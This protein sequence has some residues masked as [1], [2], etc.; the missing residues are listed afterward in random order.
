VWRNE[1]FGV[2][3]PT[4]AQIIHDNYQLSYIYGTKMKGFKIE[5]GGKVW[6]N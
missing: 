6:K 2:Q 5:L 3:T 1:E 4:S